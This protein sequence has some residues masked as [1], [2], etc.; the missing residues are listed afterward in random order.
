VADRHKTLTA[1][2]GFLSL[3]PREPELRRL[4]R[5]FDNWR[6]IGDVVAGLARQGYDLELRRYNG[7]G[8][9]AVFFL[10]ASS[11]RSRHTRAPGGRRARGRPCS[12]PPRMR[13][14]SYALVSRRHAIGPPPTTPPHDGPL[15]S[16]EERTSIVMALAAADAVSGARRR[17]PREQRRSE[18]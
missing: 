17:G 8:W 13:S 14:T 18:S 10:K 7:R 4:H 16:P 11:T 12:A 1:A 6:G 9:R 2:L 3:D 5:C 15:A